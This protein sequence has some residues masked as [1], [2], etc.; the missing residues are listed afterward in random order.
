MLENYMEILVNEVYSEVNDVYN[1]CHSPKCERDIKSIALNNLP[2]MYFLSSVS[3]G[4]KK[5][6]LV[7]RQRK[8]TVLT[9][10]TEAVEIVCD[11]CKRKDEIRANT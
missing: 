9:K 6:F 7:D 2:P 1:I 5:A 3:E 10:L 4:E 8:I 11:D